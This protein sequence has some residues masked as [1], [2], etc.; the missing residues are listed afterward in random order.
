MRRTKTSQMSWSRC[1]TIFAHQ[2]RSSAYLAMSFN[3]GPYHKWLV[4][5]HPHLNNVKAPIEIQSSFSFRCILGKQLEDGKIAGLGQF[6][7]CLGFRKACS[8]TLACHRQRAMCLSDHAQI[9]FH[10]WG[11]AFVYGIEKG[12]PLSISG[13]PLARVTYPRQCSHPRLALPV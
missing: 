11:Q 7:L 13:V 3:R 1:G 12:A 4:D 9:C 5:M 8:R 2:A 10:A 6:E